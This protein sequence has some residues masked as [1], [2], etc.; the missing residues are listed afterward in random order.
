MIFDFILIDIYIVQTLKFDWK[1]SNLENRLT[2]L[3][4]RG[5][6]QGTVKRWVASSCVILINFTK[7]QCFY[8]IA[9]TEKE[10]PY[11]VQTFPNI[12]VNKG[13]NLRLRKWPKIV[14]CMW[15]STHWAS[16][17]FYCVFA[18]WN[19]DSVEKVLVLTNFQ[20][21]KCWMLWW[22]TFS[23]IWYN[24]SNQLSKCWRRNAQ[25]RNFTSNV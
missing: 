21:L 6:M 25:S 20:F 14:F 12:L 19:G 17:S 8:Q 1:I 18:Q 23:S 11:I 22:N 13:F 24:F 2:C 7:R 9:D 16:T 4:V 5:A 10:L 15:L 3:S